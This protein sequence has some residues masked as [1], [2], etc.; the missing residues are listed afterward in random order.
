MNARVSPG[1]EV[2]AA[3][4]RPL[5]RIVIVGHVDH[6]KS[7]LIG[8]LLAET[9]SLP[10]G[11]LEQLKAVSARRG[12]PFELSFLL[13]ALQTERD[14][15]ITIDTSQ[16]RF[17]TPSRDFVLIDAPGH[18]EFLRNMITGASQ[19]DAALLI[20]DAAEGVREQTRRHGYLLHLLGVR[21][22]VVVINKMDRVS[23]DERRFRDIDA[24]I[25]AHLGS[26][27]V[28]PAAVIPISARHGDGVVARTA[29]I[30]WYDGPTVVEALDRFTPAQPA[31]AL[32]L[33]LPVQAVYKFDDRRIVAGRVESGRIAIG[34]EI[35]VAPS[36]K[37]ARVRT[38]ESWPVGDASGLTATASAGRSVGI[39]LDREL[40]IARGDLIALA[41]AGAS[42][43]RNIKARIF[44]LHD[45]PLATG[46]VVTV[47]V[48]TAEAR[49]TITAIENAVDPGEVV[50]THAAAIGQNHVGD[51]EIALAAPIAVDLHE[52]NPRTGRI[53][54][55]Y[56]G[57]IAGGGLVLALPGEAKKSAAAAAPPLIARAAELSRGLVDLDAAG[58]L[59][60]FRLEV[61]GRIAFTTSFGLEDQVILHLICE[62][63]LDVDLVTLDTGRLFPETYTTWEETEARYG[64]RIRAIYP[65]HTALEALVAAQGINGFYRSREARAACCEVR[66]VEPLNRAL[67]GAAGWVTGLRADQ[68]AHRGEV[69]LVATDPDRG[70]LKLSPLHDWTREAAV[71]FADHHAVPRN[72]LHEKGFASIGCAPCT[73]AIR[74][75]EPE[76][77]GR[78]WW[79]D[80][81]K[82]EC[83]LHLA[84]GA[85]R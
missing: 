23:Y 28:K 67:A 15:G 10:D 74:A 45:Q 2:N 27:G 54:L 58:R 8:R 85:A 51:I 55:E 68:S 62:A 79:E 61:E 16:I 83:G 75:G 36:G 40:F 66:K 22:V 4:S 46:A 14:Q 24:E 29:A 5:V 47:Q 25:S 44:W 76:R 7:T 81:G 38:I 9:G 12:M 64:R 6:G 31:T 18:T 82:K 39:T 1:L 21:Q 84:A 20:V 19:A 42:S 77:A 70:L 43:A 80:E 26:F 32:A 69:G 41:A 59:S 78:W 13:D 72:P 65:H 71:R 34:D 52:N 50:Q 33:R 57:R 35:T 30:D 17:R 60:A 63:G 3:L 53:V 37:R 11:K 49:G 48:G 56:A 73:R